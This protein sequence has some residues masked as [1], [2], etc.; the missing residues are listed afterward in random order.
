M[1]RVQQVKVPL[2]HTE[3]DIVKKACKMLRQ[4]ETEVLEYRIVKQSVDARKREQVS[5]VYTIDLRFLNEEKILKT[6][7]A[8]GVAACEGCTVL[9]PGLRKKRRMCIRR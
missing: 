2:A 1:I 8:P 3:A 5:Y 6:A 9:F 7:H 4:K